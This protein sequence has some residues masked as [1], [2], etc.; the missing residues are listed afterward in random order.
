MG[1]SEGEESLYTFLDGEV[2]EAQHVVFGVFT[3]FL[4]ELGDGVEFGVKG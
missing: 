3:I 1:L 4:L 2:V